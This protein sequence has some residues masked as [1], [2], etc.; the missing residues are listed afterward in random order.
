MSKKNAYKYGSIMIRSN[1][2]GAIV[3]IG[4]ISKT[5]PAIFDLKTKPSA[6]SVKIE[7]AGYFDSMHKVVIS[8]GAKIEINAV[9]TEVT[10]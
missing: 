1:P 9:L 7:K 6:Y 3:T 4:D 5:T 8:G 10:K 2:S